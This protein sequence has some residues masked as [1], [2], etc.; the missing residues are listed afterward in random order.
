MKHSMRALLARPGFTIVAIATLTL[1]FGVNA[2]VFALTRTVLLREL[3]YRDADRLVQVNETSASLNIT[4]GG[5]T[6]ANYA[7]WK[8]RVTAFD[9]TSFFRR[10]QFN[11]ATP[12]RPVQVEGFLISASFF[13]LLGIDVARGRGV[14]ES[15]ARV[16]PDETTSW[17]SAT[18]S[19][20]AC[21]IPIQRSSAE[22]SWSTARRAP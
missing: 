6:P 13:P 11:I 1:G 21:S 2:A 18:G 7:V 12:S 4:A 17:Y 8:E 16:R 5:I 19:G 20:G 15:D 14:Q 22:R 3:P 10:V 9:A